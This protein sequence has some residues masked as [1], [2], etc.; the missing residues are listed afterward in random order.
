MIYADLL[1]FAAPPPIEW[2][3]P[4]IVILLFVIQII[5]AVITGV[6]NPNMPQ[7]RPPGQMPRMPVPPQG[8]E[9]E[10]LKGE[11]E[12]FLKRVSTRREGQPQRPPGG[13]GP[14]PITVARGQPPASPGERRR[15]PPPVVI[16]TGGVPIGEVQAPTRRS[17]EDLAKR[18]L[19]SRGFEQ[20]GDQLTKIDE[21]E[22]QFERQVQQ[23]FAH[24]VGHLKPSVLASPEDAGAVSDAAPQVVDD[25]RSNTSFALLTGSNLINAVIINEIMQRPE[26]RW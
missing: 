25:S 9:N 21:H 26:H 16:A 2:F 15:R 6:G 14:R 8:E 23:T 22:R 18:H 3:L 4:A 11:I 5:R 12:E 1:L 17:A 7:R 10:A 20:R 24:E 13:A 19:G